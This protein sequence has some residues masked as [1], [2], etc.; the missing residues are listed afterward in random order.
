MQT[1]ADKI[2]KT[3]KR[4]KMTLPKASPIS[5]SNQEGLFRIILGFIRL[6]IKTSNNRNINMFNLCRSIFF[7]CALFFSHALCAAE[8]KVSLV[9]TEGISNPSFSGTYINDNGQVFGTIN[10]QYVY[11]SDQKKGLS[12]F[13]EDNISGKVKK[14]LDKVDKTTDFDDDDDYHD[15]DD[16]TS[17]KE[18]KFTPCL[19]SYEG[20]LIF[21]NNNQMLVKGYWGAA[22]LWNPVSGLQSINVFNNSDV[23]TIDLNDSGQVIGGYQK[24]YGRGD[25]RPFFWDNGVATDMGPGSEFTQK[26][27]AV[28]YHVMDIKLTSLNNKGEITGHFTVGKYN[29][30]QN[31][32]VEIGKRLYFYWN[33]SINIIP[34]QTKRDNLEMKLNNTGSVLIN[35]GYKTYLWN[36]E[37]GLQEIPDFYGY[38][39]N[40]SNVILGKLYDYDYHNDEERVY[41]VIWKKGSFTKISELLNKKDL[42]DLAPA[43]SDSFDVEEIKEISG[44]NNKGQIVAMGLVW[45]E[46]H[47]C[48]IEPIEAQ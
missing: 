7:I 6:F 36:I 13:S 5:G 46:W 44:I 8:Y 33:G 47:P 20:H 3:E 37:N 29:A 38:D 43:Y 30:K 9:G 35:I 31:R 1:S 10:Y 48:I 45:G 39:F 34:L 18:V 21:N 14:N 27:E 2:A 19:N 40:D 15:Y 23:Q 26:F 4:L 16:D 24:T 17:D 25:L 12:I 11:I 41:P 28:G 42:S 32:Y 22:C